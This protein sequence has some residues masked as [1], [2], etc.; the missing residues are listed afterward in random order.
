MTARFTRAL[1]ML[2]ETGLYRPWLYV[3]LST[4]VF[5]ASFRIDARPAFLARHIALSGLLYV[6]PLPLIAPSVEFRYTIWLF[7]ATVVA[8]AL[9]VVALR[10]SRA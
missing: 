8:V 5:L 10:E 2:S 1:D 6:A 4:V 9:M 3:L 7:E